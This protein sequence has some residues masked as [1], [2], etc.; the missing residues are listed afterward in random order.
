MAVFSTEE[1]THF[2]PGHGAKLMGAFIA[3]V[4]A[5]CGACYITYPD[6]PAAP[7]V[8]EGGLQAELGGANAIRV[9]SVSSRFGLMA[10]I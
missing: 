10:N 5:L 2:T 3:T 4:L 8:F 6:K 7:R 9:R 1:Y